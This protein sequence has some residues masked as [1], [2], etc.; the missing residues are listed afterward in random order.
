MKRIVSMNRVDY[1]CKKKSLNE[2]GEE[3]YNRYIDMMKEKHIGGLIRTLCNMIK[4]VINDLVEEEEIEK[5]IDQVNKCLEMTNNELFI[6]QKTYNFK[7]NGLFIAITNN[8]TTKPFIHRF[9]LDKM[10]LHKV[11]SLLELSI[12]TP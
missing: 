12:T 9:I 7:H 1:L 2:I 5:F 4:I 8:N 10:N 6:F 11:K 3:N